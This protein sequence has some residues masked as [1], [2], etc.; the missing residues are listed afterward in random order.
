MFKSNKSDEDL[1]KEYGVVYTNLSDHLVDGGRKLL[2]LPQPRI[3]GPTTKDSAIYMN[4][5]LL[6]EKNPWWGIVTL[7]HEATH[8]YAST[9]DE[10]YFKP[11]EGDFWQWCLKSAATQREMWEL[12]GE[13]EAMEDRSYVNVVDYVVATLGRSE[14]DNIRRMGTAK[15][16]NNA[17]GLA[18]YAHSVVGFPT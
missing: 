4:F 14:I 1:K 6:V 7:I 2:G 13:K 9:T 17:D 15:S 10:Q 5:S 3:V 8:K 11:S 12:T 16:L 18:R